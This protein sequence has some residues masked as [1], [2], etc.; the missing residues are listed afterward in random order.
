[1]KDQDRTKEQLISELTAM[2]Q[3]VTEL[4]ELEFEREQAELALQQSR[5]FAEAI[6]E[7]IREPLV[8]LDAHLTVLSANWSFCDTFQVTLDETVGASIFDLGDRQ[9][10]IPALR[11]LLEDVLPR[12]TKF[13]D[14]E[15]EHI[16]PSIGHKIML[17]NARR[18]YQEGTGTQKILLAIEDITDRRRAEQAL[19]TS[20]T[21]YR[22][23]FETA[24]D[25]ILI[26]EAETGQ[27]NDVN[28]FLMDMLGYTSGEFLGK[29]LW[30]IGAFKDIE[31]SKAAFKELQSKGY[32]RYE[33]LPLSTRDG[34]DIAVEFVS[35]VYP[36]NH[37]K[38]IQCNI[39][40]IT[41]RKQAEE[42]QKRLILQLRDALSKVRTLH[43]MLPICSSCKKIRN[44][45]GYWEQVESYIGGHSEAEF[46]HGICPDCSKTLYPQF[47]EKQ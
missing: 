11:T 47:H 7:T 43:G 14:Y 23:L 25:G 26:L 1:M 42:E 10:D 21:R 3:R 2:Q 27:I 29:Q 45:E 38:V 4:E 13:D 36:V 22:R 37:H 41:D 9:W 17:L 18:I 35:N 30:E 19:K 8:V 5:S 31:A 28:P 33:D 16:F 12:N 15:V 20:E 39:R 46:T 40:N 44:D 32:V 34:H 24:Q 6:T